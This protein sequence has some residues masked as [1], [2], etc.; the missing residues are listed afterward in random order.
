MVQ[1]FLP[2]CKLCIFFL[3]PQF[4]WRLSWLRYEVLVFLL[5]IIVLGISF[6]ESFYNLP[7]FNKHLLQLRLHFLDRV[8]EPIN[9]RRLLTVFIINPLELITLLKEV[10]VLLL[11]LLMELLNLI[12]EK[13]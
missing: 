4:F 6:L 5:E 11:D 13:L 12:L 1:D 2:L 8:V 9:H 7:I 3:K 10:P